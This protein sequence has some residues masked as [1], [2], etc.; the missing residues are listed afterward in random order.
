MQLTPP[1][2]RRWSRSGGVGDQ[3]SNYSPNRASQKR[4][5]TNGTPGSRLGS[6]TARAERCVN[7]QRQAAIFRG[8]AAGQILDQIETSS[9]LQNTDRALLVAEG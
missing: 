9:K 2:N 6:S 4:C 1:P 7:P 3:A 5:K 8:G